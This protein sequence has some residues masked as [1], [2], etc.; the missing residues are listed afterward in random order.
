MELEKKL[1]NYVLEPRFE[2][3]PSKMVR[4]MKDV[5]LNVFGAIVAGATV[6]ACP[7][8]VQQAIQWGG[9]A[10]ATI[11]VYGNRVSAPNAAFANGFMARALVL[12][13]AMVGGLHT[14]GSAIPAALAAAETAGGC[15]GKEFLASLVTATELASRLHLSTFYN[16]FDATGVCVIFAATAAAARIMGLGREEMWHA[17]GHAFNRSGGSWQGTIDG[18]VAARVLQGTSA[19]GGIASAQLAR[20]GISGPQELPPGRLRLFPPLR[21]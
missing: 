15:T 7:E 16:G 8:A 19:Q 2:E 11:L 1:V 6:P 4:L 9:K 10:E 3:L 13:E 17:L 5:V 20:K 12:D 21:R 18:S 14:G